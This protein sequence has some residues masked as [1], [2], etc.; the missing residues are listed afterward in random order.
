MKKYVITYSL[1]FM[2][3]LLIGTLLTQCSD[4][5]YASGASTDQICFGE[6][7]M[8]EWL[9]SESDDGKTR[10]VEVTSFKS[11]TYTKYLVYAWAK[12]KDGDYIK[13]ISGESVKSSSGVIS[14]TNY[15]WPSSDY[16]M[17]FLALAP[18]T[19]ASSVN[20]DEKG[21]SMNYTVP[22]EVTE[23]SDL[24]FALTDQPNRGE[25]VPLQ[26]GHMLTSVQVMLTKGLKNVEGITK[27][28]LKNV[29]GSGTMTYALD[30]DN[31]SFVWSSLDDKKEFISTYRSGVNL[32]SGTSTFMM[33]P[34]NFT[35]DGGNSEAEIVLYFADGTTRSCKLADTG[36]DWEAGHRVTYTLS[37]AAA[38][39][40]F[41]VPDYIDVTADVTSIEIPITSKLE[42]TEDD[43]LK[44]T[45]RGWEIV[46]T[47]SDWLNVDDSNTNMS[48]TG[49]LTFTTSAAESYVEGDKWLQ[50][51]TPK[52]GVVDLSD[53]CQNTANCYII[54][55]AGTYKFPLVYGNAIENGVDNTKAYGSKNFYNHRGKAIK[56]PYIYNNDKCTPGSVEL[57]WQDREGLI[58]SVELSDDNTYI[59]F[60][61]A[62]RS[63]IGQGNAVIAVRDNTAEK[64]IMWSWHIWVTYY[65]PNQEP[66]FNDY[67]KDK[68]IIPRTV[69]TKSKYVIMPINLGWCDKCKYYK[70]RNGEVTIKQTATGETKT[71]KIYQ[72]PMIDGTNG[73]QPHYQWSRKDPFIPFDASGG[74][75]QTEDAYIPYPDK[76]AYD[77]I[78]NAVTIKTD[79]T[80]FS[81]QKTILNPDVFMVF[82]NNYKM[83]GGDTPWQY[84]YKT[85]Y[86]PSPV[87]YRVTEKQALS[88]ITTEDGSGFKISSGK[89]NTPFTK[90]Y[91]ENNR[92]IEVNKAN[93]W[94]FYCHPKVDGKV[95]PSGGTFFMPTS[96]FRQF[97][98]GSDYPG[99][100]LFDNTSKNNY[101]GSGTVGVIVDNN[102]DGSAYNVAFMGAIVSCS[103]ST[104]HRL[105]G[106]AIRCM[107]E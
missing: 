11:S 24:L 50:D 98:T 37:Y 104:T 18:T 91:N 63:D 66:D 103:T 70:G 67:W 40:V 45:Q 72:R 57:L 61:T 13:Y 75:D 27:V 83:W 101:H 52:S 23:Q 60:T 87:G 49:K 78:G 16:A 1:T 25:D 38:V 68:E 7:Q 2:L 35:G 82:K 44:V 95:D 41:D 17:R 29:Y 28:S 4:E 79:E 43:S 54:N 107:K 15:F 88:V 65:V 86:D 89:I 10:G 69:G 74:F 76:A 51:Q 47:P 106:R 42:T 90:E 46:G 12:P 39:N 14:G 97:L 30:G 59:K 56:N 105:Y 96:L 99:Q 84:G 100:V 48:G 62:E 20:F 93:G 8:A 5:E 92:Y 58:K 19:L 94:V 21:I 3:M 73:S 36:K 32:A 80:K 53:G 85:I 77:I 6:A 33:L 81:L 64:N 22:D 31:D 55:A 34:Q 71:V 9:S 26:F 102:T